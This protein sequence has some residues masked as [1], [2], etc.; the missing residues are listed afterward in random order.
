MRVNSLNGAAQAVIALGSPAIAAVLLTTV[1]LGLI[2]LVDAVASALAVG[3]MLLVH[4]PRIERADAPQHATGLAAYG[5]EIAEALRTLRR[6]AALLRVTIVMAFMVC[7]IAPMAQMTPV[8]IARYFGPEQWKLAAGEICWS[9][10]MVAGGLVMMA[11]GGMR[12]RMSLIMG[13]AVSWVF[14]AAGMGASPTLLIFC[15]VMVIWG[16]SLS[17]LNASVTTSAQEQ[18]E[19]HMLGRVMGL[20]SLVLNLAG[21]IGMAA[22]GP[23]SDVIPLRYLCLAMAA[24]AA[25]FL[26]LIR[27]IGGPGQPLMAP[28]IDLAVKGVEDAVA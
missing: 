24:I 2:F 22:F 17:M 10:G 26:L 3:L 16:G 27:L 15:V 19:T 11:W 6:H 4:L 9:A 20:F 12:N 7:F 18:I 25:V 28:A 14:L 1:P 5:H 13:I 21:P 8:F 23:L